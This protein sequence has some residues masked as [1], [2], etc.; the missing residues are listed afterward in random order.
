MTSIA[1]NTQP[2]AID[3]VAVA[4][5]RGSEEAS[6]HLLHAVLLGIETLAQGNK[7]ASGKALDDALTRFL[8]DMSTELGDGMA[9]NAAKL[10]I[11]NLARFLRRDRYHAVLAALEVGR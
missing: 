11:S 3:L 4:E 1:L 9:E 6:A 7:L 10:L 5:H 2:G 8:M